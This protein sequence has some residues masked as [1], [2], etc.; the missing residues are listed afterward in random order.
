MRRITI[1]MTLLA[2]AL[3]GTSVPTATAVGQVQTFVAPASGEQEVPP[4]DSRA[5]GQAVFQ[6]DADGAALHYRLIV[7]NLHDV[8][9]AHIHLA[10]AGANGPVVVWLYPDGPPAQLIPGRSS[11]VLAAG[12]ITAGDLVGP[13]AGM[14]LADLVD[15]MQAGN[16][17]V[18][19]HTSA[20]PAGEVRGQIR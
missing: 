16:T 3:L 4:N 1:L 11:G 2:M 13:L 9:M 6:L 15:E 14:S 12:T 5:R 18:N 7:A 20:F 19:V 10:P 17:Y 8:T